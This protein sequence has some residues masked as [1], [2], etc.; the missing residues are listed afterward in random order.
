LAGVAFLFSSSSPS[1]EIT[2]SSSPS[3]TSTSSQS[4]PS[5]FLGFFSTLVAYTSLVSS[6]PLSSVE[7]W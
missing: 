7:G 3:S 4:S 2:S 1:D 5:T 6:S